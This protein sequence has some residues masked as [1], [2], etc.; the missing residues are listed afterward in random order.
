MF[1][2][3]SNSDFWHLM[4]P[5]N[6]ESS[7]PQANDSQGVAELPLRAPDVQLMGEMQG[8]GFQ[9]RQ[10]LIQR[11]RQFFQLTELLYKVLEAAD[12]HRTIEEIAAAVSDSTEWL[13]TGDDVRKLIAGKLVPL[14]LISSASPQKRESTRSPLAV[15]MRMRMIGPRVLDPLTKLF[16]VFFWPPVLI[17]IICAV[18]VAHW[19]MYR[20]QGLEESVRETL[21]T[22]GGLLAVVLIV[23]VGGFFH[24]LGHASAL[25]YGGGR[26]RRMGV[27]LYLIYPAFFT[28]VTDAY[29]LTRMARIRTDLGGVY[30]HAIFVLALTMVAITSGWQVVL[31]AA[32]LIN[33]DIAR[34]FI[35]FVRLDGYWLVADI[36]GIP[37]LFSQTGPFLRSMFRIRGWTGSKLPRLKPWVKRTFAIYIAATV[38]VLTYL[39]FRLAKGLPQ[40]LVA[41]WDGMTKQAAMFANAQMQGDLIVM[42]LLATS[43]LFLLLPAVGT[44]Y[45]LLLALRGCARFSSAVAKIVL[46]KVKLAH[47]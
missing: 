27:G 30:F 2:K 39:L 19:W 31:F 12:G 3:L 43:M 16:Q 26:A 8:S 17:P 10:W 28:D 1:E 22:P 4:T 42:V 44:L 45:I 33:L 15:Y 23:I 41:A 11:D 24:E 38:P 29:G 9:D 5:L 36:T 47:A 13:L 34:Q 32:L 37:D 46:S 18:A 6:V 21:R 40:V 14:G 25:R 20:V 7:Q 35:P